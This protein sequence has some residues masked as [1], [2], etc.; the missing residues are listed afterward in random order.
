MPI[1]KPIEKN[2]LKQMKTVLSVR[3]RKTDC[4]SVMKI[5]RNTIN[6]ILKKGRGEEHNVNKIMG[7]IN[8]VA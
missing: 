5:P 4:A 6:R 3:G 7:Y 1:T 2:T 8:K